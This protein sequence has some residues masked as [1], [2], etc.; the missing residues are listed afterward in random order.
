[1]KED[2]DRILKLIDEGPGFHQL[3]C[4]GPSHISRGGMIS[5]HPLTLKPLA[6]SDSWHDGVWTKK[7]TQRPM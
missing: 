4:A 2:K 5:H 6:F 7:G 3:N 1:M